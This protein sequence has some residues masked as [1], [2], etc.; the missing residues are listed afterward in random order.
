M[1][2]VNCVAQDATASSAADSAPGSRS[3]NTRSGENASDAE[4]SCPGCTPASR[5]AAFAP[6]MRGVT[7]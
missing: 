1:A 5:A 6:M 7:P 2:G 3:R 4:T